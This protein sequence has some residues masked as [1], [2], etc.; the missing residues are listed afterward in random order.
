MARKVKANKPPSELELLYRELLKFG[1]PPFCLNVRRSGYMGTAAFFALGDENCVPLLAN[2]A[3]DFISYAVEVWKNSSRNAS[4]NWSAKTEAFGT[5]ALFAVG[6]SP[7]WATLKLML[8]IAAR[9]AAD[10][11]Q[12]KAV[13]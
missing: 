11:A 12:Q 13:K 8:V 9:Y 1:L 7:A 6:K 2:H 4:E 10:K 5:P 3:H